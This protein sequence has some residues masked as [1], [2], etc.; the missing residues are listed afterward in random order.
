VSARRTPSDPGDGNP[1]VRRTPGAEPEEE[2]QADPPVSPWNYPVEPLPQHGS[3][4]AGQQ[5]QGWGETGDQEPDT[6]EEA[7]RRSAQWG[8]LRPDGTAAPDWGASVGSP[9][10]RR[11]EHEPKRRPRGLPKVVLPILAALVVVAVVGVVLL[12]ALGGDEPSTSTSPSGTPSAA[13][14][15]PGP[16][17]PASPSTYVP[18]ANAI[19][20]AYGVSVVPAP[21][22][23]VFTP[24]TEG[25]EL[26]PTGPNS[27][28]T[29][30]WVRQRQ[31]LGA[32]EY[33]IRI[34]E[35]ETKGGSQVRASATQ[36]LGCRRDVLV[37]CVS[38]RYSM[39]LP[40]ERSGLAMRCEVQAFRRK[41]GVVTAMDFC[42]RPAFYAEAYADARL[43]LKSV[44]DSQ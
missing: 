24:E 20:V 1:W 35:G 32:E 25:K 3:D 22:W 23:T 19:P 17:T 34:F 27:R 12:K 30:F 11:P 5:G 40:K 15:T 8:T 9:S 7:E 10:L 44:I 14:S 43:M 16:S 36:K 41:D 38:I 29:W 31:K 39:L 2:V 6:A 13:T 28:S 26:V 18:P 4:A 33:A 42:S 21:G 37:E